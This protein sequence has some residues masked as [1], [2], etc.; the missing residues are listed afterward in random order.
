M[1]RIQQPQL[2]VITVSYLHTT[3]SLGPPRVLSSAAVRIFEGFGYDIALAASTAESDQ[4]LLTRARPVAAAKD[5]ASSALGYHRQAEHA[6]RLAMA[7]LTLAR[8]AQEA[9]HLL[10]PRIRSSAGGLTRRLQP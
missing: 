7:A 1:A 9:D 6:M 2:L 5:T 4:A 8:A 10:K 3:P